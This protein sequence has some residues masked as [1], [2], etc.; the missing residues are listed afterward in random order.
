MA[1]DTTPTTPMTLLEAVNI[2]LEAARV[3]GV[4]SLE[5]TNLN[6]DAAA[7]KS[8]LDDVTREVL[9]TGWE[10]NTTRGFIIDP[11]VDGSITLPLDTASVK[12]SRGYSGNRL[13]PRGGKLYDPKLRTYTVGKSVTVDL[14]QYLEFGD[15]TDAMKSY[16]TALAARRFAI[17]RLPSPSNFKFTDEMIQGF[18]TALEQEDTDHDD[19]DISEISPH[20]AKFRRR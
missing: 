2:L 18:L 4:D 8:A 14:V 12:I 9:R 1:L 10:Q 11:D 19:R 17:P 15:L 13:V 6:E 7:A 20:F 16:I 5:Q 3:A